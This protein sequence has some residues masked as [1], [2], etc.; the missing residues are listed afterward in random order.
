MKDFSHLQHLS[1][2]LSTLVR[3][4][5]VIY[6]NLYSSISSSLYLKSLTIIDEPDESIQLPEN[7][8]FPSLR[9]LTIGSLTMFDVQ[10][11]IQSAPE[12]DYFKFHLNSDRSNFLF[13]QNL[14]TKITRLD[15][16]GP[17]AEFES[18]EKFLRQM[19]KLKSLKLIC[20]GIDAIIWKC[21]INEFLPD[22]ID[23]RFK[24]DIRQKNFI[25]NE[26]E[27]DWWKNEKKWIVIHHPLSP[28]IYTIP[29]IETKLILNARTAFRQEV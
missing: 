15:I 5:S 10:R 29:L 13:E 28:N 21:F 19:K 4:P 1:I 25:L 18:I 7:L 16:D 3:M 8:Y 12:L 11:I 27:T 9:N 23:F 22:L 14:Q 26:Y 24:F 20:R 17:N 2:R 6:T